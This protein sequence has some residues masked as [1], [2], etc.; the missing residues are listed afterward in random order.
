VAHSHYREERREKKKEEKKNKKK[1]QKEK[2]NFYPTL[3][4]SNSETCS[5]KRDIRSSSL[6]EAFR[7]GL[8]GVSK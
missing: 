5:F 1:S 4:R 6:I 8:M 2:T 3:T 7:W